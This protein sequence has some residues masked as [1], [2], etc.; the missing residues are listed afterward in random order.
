LLLVNAG[1]L[2]ANAK[3][4]EL[5][6]DPN[7]VIPSFA[8]R[9][10]DLATRFLDEAFENLRR[11]LLKFS[12]EDPK[13]FEELIDALADALKEIVI[14]PYTDHQVEEAKRATA[15]AFDAVI[16]DR[17]V[18]TKPQQ[19]WREAYNGFVAWSEENPQIDSDTILGWKQAVLALAD[20]LDRFSFDY[21]LWLNA[22]RARFRETRGAT[23]ESN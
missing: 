16:E 7:A 5:A 21:S 13:R 22:A 20:A 6:N 10:S 18:G 8:P 3:I 9:T 15:N 14:T 4:V 17:V 1:F 11:D 19:L 12:S 23:D 2:P